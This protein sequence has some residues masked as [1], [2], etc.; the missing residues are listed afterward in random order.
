MEDYADF[1][2]TVAPYVHMGLRSEGLTN[3]ESM[4]E[5]FKCAGDLDD[6]LTVFANLQHEFSISAWRRDEP[7]LSYDDRGPTHL[8][9]NLYGR[10][11]ARELLKK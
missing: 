11:I 10:Y 3:Q 4:R 7:I 8:K 6:F 1:F 9:M 2:W 5:V